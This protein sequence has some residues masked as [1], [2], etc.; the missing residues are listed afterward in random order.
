M[1]QIYVCSTFISSPR[2]VTKN[3]K[4]LVETLGLKALLGPG[5]TMGS[6]INV[7]LVRTRQLSWPDQ[8]DLSELSKVRFVKRSYPIYILLILVSELVIKLDRYH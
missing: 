4:P 6:K 2:S 5:K 1:Q 8:G 7:Y 3:F